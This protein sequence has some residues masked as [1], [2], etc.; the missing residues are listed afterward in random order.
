LGD[1]R[2]LG[3]LPNIQGLSGVDASLFCIGDEML[4]EALRLIR[5]YH[6]AKQGDVAERLGISKSYLSEIEKGRKKPT[7]EIVE[8]YSSVF[9]IPVSSIMFFSEHI[10]G[11]RSVTNVR[12]AIA[13]KIVKLLRFIEAR[14]DSLH[15]EQ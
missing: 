5:V 12:L 3:R 4:N 11:G 1:P 8:K 13:G 14:S 15:A 7:L 9:G 2:Y 6:D 10:E